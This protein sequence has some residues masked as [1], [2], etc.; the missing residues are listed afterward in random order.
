MTEPMLEA[1]LVDARGLNR[2]SGVTGVLLCS[3]DQFMQYFEGSTEAMRRTYD[4]ILASR[5]HTQIVE[6]MNEP[7]PVRDF[8]AWEMALAKPSPSEMMALSTARWATQD[9][10]SVA[11]GRP[12]IGM[13]LLRDFW[14]RQHERR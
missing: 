10:I 9:A 13:T 7:I 8:Q 5:S 1:L 2:E 3:D 6:M 4:R 14:R 11:R 12:S